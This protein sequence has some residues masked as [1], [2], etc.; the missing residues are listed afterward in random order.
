MTPRISIVITCYNLGAYL[1]EALDSIAEYPYPAYYEVVIVDDGSTDPETIRVLD[2]IDGD[3]H[4][5]IRQAN[6]GLGKARNNGV[7]VA[8]GDYI[9]PLDADNRLRPA[10][11]SETLRVLDDNP[12]V[13]V[14]YGNSMYFGDRNGPWQLAPFDFKRL[15]LQNYIDACAGFRRTLW[16]RLGGY[17]EGMPVMGYEDWDFWLRSSVAGARFHH[18]DQVFFDYRV[19]E[20]SMLG[21]AVLHG[22]LLV[23][24]IFNKPELVFLKDLRAAHI[25]SV[26]RNNTILTGRELLILLLARLQER[27][28]LGKR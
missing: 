4:V 6:T 23:E 21:N 26:A 8:R 13:D 27:F 5:V 22:P 12:A 16:D 17:D 14:V 10:M 19:R 2:Q 11:I 28:G 18:V 3:R 20:G 15:L 1:Q 7:R 9:I 24:H 25:A